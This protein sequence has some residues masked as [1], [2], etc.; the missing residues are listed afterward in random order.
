[1]IRNEEISAKHRFLNSF[2]AFLKK[3][4][5]AL[6]IILI[7]FCVVIV[8]L[9]VFNEIQK[10]R[11]QKSSFM[12][13]D[14]LD[15]YEEWLVLEDEEKTNEE[16]YADLM[17]RV[18][19][20]L[21][22][23]PK[24]FAAQNAYFLKANIYYEVE[25]WVEAAANYQVIADLFP[26]SYFA[27]IGLSNAAVCFE[28][29]DQTDNAKSMYSRILNDYRNTFPGTTRVLLSLGR[30]SESQSDFEGAARYYNDLIDN[31]NASSW[32]KLARNRIIYLTAQNKIEE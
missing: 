27:P 21:A 20:I 15:D 22:S 30:I 6:L 1:M 19:S 3:N 24:S 8:G 16:S 13:E 14:A 18:D 17:T 10:N 32:T 28:Q 2:S 5:T 11:S 25:N 7:V 31:F 29:L 4:K 26:V 9:L 23:Y 12:I